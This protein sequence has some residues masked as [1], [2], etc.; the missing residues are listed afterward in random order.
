MLSSVEIQCPYC[1]EAIVLPIDTS[2][3]DEQRYIED[4]QVCC[5]AISI[6]VTLDDGIAQVVASA[7]NDA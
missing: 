5:R 1:G 3:I 6:A 4:C 2:V 7:E